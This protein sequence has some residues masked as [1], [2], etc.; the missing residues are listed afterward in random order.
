MTL[1]GTQNR[2]VCFWKG[3]KGHQNHNWFKVVQNDGSQELMV[4]FV[5][6]RLH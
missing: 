1:K 5:I 3:K 4:S 6:G 2:S